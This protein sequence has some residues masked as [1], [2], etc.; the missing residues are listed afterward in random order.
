VA[1]SFQLAGPA[2]VFADP[3]KERWYLQ[4]RAVLTAAWIS[5]VGRPPVP[6]YREPEKARRKRLVGS[7]RGA[8]SKATVIR[9]RLAPRPHA[10]ITAAA[11]VGKR[12][13]CC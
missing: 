8:A 1:D 3:D 11:P 7:H 4:A 2:F 6:N 13:T 5:Y 12:A 10:G 9:Q